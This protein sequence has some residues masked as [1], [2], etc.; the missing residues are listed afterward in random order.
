[1]ESHVRKS[2]EE[3]KEEIGVLLH[4]IDEEYEQ[5]KKELQ[6]YMYKFSI[7]KQVVQS[8]ANPDLNRKIRDLYHEPFQAKYN[9]LKEYIKDLEEKKRVFQ[10]FVDKIDK[11]K[12]KEETKPYAAALTE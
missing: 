5:V 11:V 12:D 9:E 7:T 1:M 8:T 4:E 2:L 3:W 10:M 6:V